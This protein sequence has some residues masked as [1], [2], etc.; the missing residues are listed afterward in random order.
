[1]S[2]WG[3]NLR[4]IKCG[5]LAEIELDETSKEPDR[6]DKRVKGM[7]AVFNAWDQ[8]LRGCNGIAR[9]DGWYHVISDPG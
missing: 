8:H 9:Q 1:M 3:F 2:L 6:H 7:A 4:C 5:F